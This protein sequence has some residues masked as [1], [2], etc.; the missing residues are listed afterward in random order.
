MNMSNALFQVRKEED[1]HFCENHDF[2]SLDSSVDELDA[3]ITI[4][5]IIQA[6]SNLKKSKHVPEIIY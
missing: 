3:A 4:D 1:E 5:E 6:I 2:D